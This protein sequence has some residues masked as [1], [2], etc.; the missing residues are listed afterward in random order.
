M[1][2]NY[3]NKKIM[4]GCERW[5]ICPERFPDFYDNQNKCN[6][7]PRDKITD[8]LRRTINRTITP[9]VAEKFALVTID[10]D[11]RTLSMNKNDSIIIRLNLLLTWLA[12]HRPGA[13]SHPL[14]P[15]GG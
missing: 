12:V 10:S 4:I 3:N 8:E 6:S 13:V 1:S 15:S 9:V 11:E 7:F 5:E 14:A 2:F